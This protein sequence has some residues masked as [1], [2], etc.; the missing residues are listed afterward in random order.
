MIFCFFLPVL[1]A[2]HGLS[3]ELERGVEVSLAVL[4]L[5]C[6]H[7]LSDLEKAGLLLGHDEVYMGPRS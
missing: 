1:C 4:D 3:E 5:S 7:G 2:P 6:E